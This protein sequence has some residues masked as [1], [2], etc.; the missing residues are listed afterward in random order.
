MKKDKN[1][2]Q[3]KSNLTG[4][5]FELSSWDVDLSEWDTIVPDWNI[6]LPDWD[7]PDLPPCSDILEPTKGVRTI[8]RN[9]KHK[10]R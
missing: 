1:R 4:W 7:V 9:K 2:L 3:N 5:G 8:E 6:E 10:N